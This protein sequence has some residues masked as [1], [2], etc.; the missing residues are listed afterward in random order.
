M[1]RHN[2]EHIRHHRER[3]INKRLNILRMIK[4]SAW[5]PPPGRL[6]KFNLSCNCLMC[7]KQNHEDVRYHIRKSRLSDEKCWDEE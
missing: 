2:T 1:R 6:A 4:G 5:N 3:Y 7:N